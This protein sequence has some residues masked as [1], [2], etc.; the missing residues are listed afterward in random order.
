MRADVVVGQPVD[1]V[2]AA[3]RAADVVC[4]A[5]RLVESEAER[6][7]VAQ[8]V[9]QLRDT[10]LD[11]LGATECARLYAEGLRRAAAS[12]AAR[13]RVAKAVWRGIREELGAAKGGGSGARQRKAA[14]QSSLAQL[15]STY[16]ADPQLH[17]CA[18]LNARL[19]AVAA[20]AESLAQGT[21]P[22][23]RLELPARS[24]APLLDCSLCLH[25]F[26]AAEPESAAHRIIASTAAGFGLA[27]E[28]AGPRH[29]S[30]VAEEPVPSPDVVA[31]ADHCL[32]GLEWTVKQS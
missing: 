29:A 26:A 4:A 32:Q 17:N 3:E 1:A 6:E 14:E 10:G 8:G 23:Q 16:V 27:R 31:A 15:L 19:G 5:K 30:G 2:K 12:A 18:A 25:F 11:A 9:Q 7:R 28:L 24:L 20:L 22:L 21:S 13:V